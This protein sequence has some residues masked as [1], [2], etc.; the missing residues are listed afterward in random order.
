MNK[1]AEQ[2][3]HIDAS[4]KPFY[5]DSVSV[6]HNQNQFIMDFKQTTP[7]MD[8]VGV[9]QKINFVTIHDTVVMPPMVAKSM[10]DILKDS[11]EK[12]E[13]N[14]GKI[15]LPKQKKQKETKAETVNDSYIG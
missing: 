9:E 4:N 5:S 7:R 8:V 12:Y 11:V 14:F 13:K 2:E 10:L 1:K 15:K 3:F 6:L